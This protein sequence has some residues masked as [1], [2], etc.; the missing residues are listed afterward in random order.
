MHL[1]VM[2]YKS[3]LLD[4]RFVRLFCPLSDENRGCHHGCT[5]NIAVEKIATQWEC[6]LFKS[7]PYCPDIEELKDL[8]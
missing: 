8:G 2:N 1:Q 4:V 7:F 5:R 3:D 6:P